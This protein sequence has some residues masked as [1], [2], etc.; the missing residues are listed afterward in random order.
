LSGGAGAECASGKGKKAEA[1]QQ[2]DRHPVP[3]FVPARWRDEAMQW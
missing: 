3:A 2:L 1:A